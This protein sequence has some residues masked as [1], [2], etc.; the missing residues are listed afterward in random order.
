MLRREAKAALMLSIW[1]PAYTF[2]FAAGRYM[3]PEIHVFLAVE[4]KPVVPVPLY[5]PSTY[6]TFRPLTCA[7]AAPTCSNSRSKDI[8]NILAVLSIF[9]N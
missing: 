7:V 6:P 3:A 4:E 5:R 2:N 8:N 9:V 1:L